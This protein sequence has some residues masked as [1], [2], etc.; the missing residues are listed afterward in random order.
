MA[1][2]S[3][4]SDT[5]ATGGGKVHHRDEVEV[6]VEVTGI[7]ATRQREQFRYGAKSFQSVTKCPLRFV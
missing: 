4:D 6:V 1:A 5:S 3:R 7:V 2:V